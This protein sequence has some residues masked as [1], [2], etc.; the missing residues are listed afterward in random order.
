MKKPTRY[1]KEGLRN[2]RYHPSEYIRNNYAS[3]LE[4]YIEHLETK[5]KNIGGIGDVIHC[6]LCTKESKIGNKVNKICTQC[7]KEHYV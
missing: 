6:D 7:M 3:D 1:T 4:K 5:L 2:E